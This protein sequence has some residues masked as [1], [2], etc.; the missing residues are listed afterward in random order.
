MMKRNSKK[1]ELTMLRNAKYNQAD[2]EHLGMKWYQFNIYFRM[3]VPIIRLLVYIEMTASSALLFPDLFLFVVVY[4]VGFIVCLLLA[5]HWMVYFKYEGVIGY[6]TV[7]FGLPVLNLLISLTGLEYGDTETFASSLSQLI[8]C[9]IIFIPELIYWKKRIHLFDRSK[10]HKTKNCYVNNDNK[11]SFC[12]K[13]GFKLTGESN[14]CSK[15]GTK[16]IGDAEVQKD[17]MQ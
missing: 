9:L 2:M 12:R 7:Q 3:L 1:D 6:F 5:R 13:C 17:E 16:V 14:F 4:R 8:A 10:K 11:I 15:C